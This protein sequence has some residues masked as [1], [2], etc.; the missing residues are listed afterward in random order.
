MGDV[1]LKSVL[2][3]AYNLENTTTAVIRRTYS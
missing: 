2:Y 1:I 3:R